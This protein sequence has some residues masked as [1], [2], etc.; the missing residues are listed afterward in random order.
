MNG[1]KPRG[2]LTDQCASIESGIRHVLAPQTVHRYCSWHILHKLPTKWGQVSN[3]SAKSDMVKKVVYKSQTIQE[4]E[5]SW[6]KLMDEVGKQNDPWF[7]G[8]FELREKWVP[9]FLNGQFWAG[10][11]STQRVESMNSFLN[12]YLTKRESLKDFVENFEA[13]LKNIWQNENQADHESKYK[14]PKLHYDFPMEFQF[15]CSYTNEI[16]YK[17]QEQFRK[18]VNLSCKLIEEQNEEAVYE[19]TDCWNKSFVVIYRRSLREVLCICR[20]FEAM[21][22]VCAHCIQVL[23]QEKIYSVEEKYNVDRWRKDVNRCNLN[24]VDPSFSSIPEQSRYIY[25]LLVFILIM[26]LNTYNV[27]VLDIIGILYPILLLINN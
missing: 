4:F 18:C 2:I 12:A 6:L 9:V 24:I 5:E 15:V 17:C 22:I 20:M 26:F 25:D 19:V 3:K 27:Y 21:G 14:A 8:I 1:V 13:A 11:T 23:K 7:R 10:M 16:F